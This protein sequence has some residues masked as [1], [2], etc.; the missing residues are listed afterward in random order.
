M[1]PPQ[2]F[3]GFCIVSPD[4]ELIFTT[5]STTE[6]DSIREWVEQEQ[7]MNFIANMGRGAR[8][9]EQACAKSWEGFEAEGYRVAPIVLQQRESK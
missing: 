4:N 6:A 8:G 3:E 9:E 5:V 7:S 2:P 1:N